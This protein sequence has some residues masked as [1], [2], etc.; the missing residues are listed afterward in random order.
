MKKHFLQILVLS[1]FITFCH[2]KQLPSP[3]EAYNFY[4]SC[5]KGNVNDATQFLTAYP[6]YADIPLYET[7]S[8]LKR[9]IKT[10]TIYNNAS[11]QRFFNYLC[12]EGKIQFTNEEIDNGK[13]R[14]L[15]NT[16]KRY[17]INVAARYGN[18]EIVKL[19]LSY[20]ADINICEENGNT[21]L[22]S[23]TQ[24]NHLEV[25]KEL[26]NKQ[27]KVNYKNDND[28]TAL[29][30]SI[31]NNYIEIVEY[32][33]EN[34]ADV[35]L[36]TEGYTPLMFASHYGKI[37]IVKLL[38][39]KNANINAQTQE[40][41]TALQF[42]AMN[43]EKE[44]TDLLISNGADVNAKNNTGVTALMEA[45]YKNDF[46]ITKSL[47]NANVDINAKEING[48]NALDIA[49]SQYEEDKKDK[50][51]V[52]LLIRS[53][54]E[55]SNLS[56]DK[57]I[58][59]PPKVIPASDLK[60]TLSNEDDYVIIYKYIGKYKNIIFPSQIEGFPVRQIGSNVFDDCYKITFERVEIP[61]S[62]TV[63]KRDAFTGSKI[64][65]LIIP[66]NVQRIESLGKISYLE[67]LV[68]PERLQ[69]SSF[70]IDFS[71]SCNL[72]E[73]KFPHLIGSSPSVSIYTYK[74]SK[75]NTIVFPE[76]AHYVSIGGDIGNIKEIHLPTSTEYLTGRV[77]LYPSTR[78]IVPFSNQIQFSYYW[79]FIESR[80]YFMPFITSN[81][82]LRERKEI[83]DFWRNLGYDGSFS[84]D[85]LF[86][87]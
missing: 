55:S 40:G 26:L 7:T 13:K 44:I 31:L 23:A 54:A 58:E 51:I 46:E 15:Q 28:L 48:Y 87:F 83:Q 43:K 73:V 5:A 38:L 63:I 86:N 84:D 24:N 62:V 76:E 17:P 64:K 9:Y 75:I 59:Y 71:N 57:Y 41:Q 14:K 50:R 56:M 72:N 12:D 53:G 19:L 37:E 80:G 29:N 34:N 77:L 18:L 22:I 69:Q 78:F 68:L 39:S 10:K 49:I 33:L 82:T 1:I 52:N 79:P 21:P 3:E 65:Q 30:L 36:T 81:C 45:V 74:D 16:Y 66:N 2:Q 25:V 20:N 67:K 4:I 8:D 6:E 11:Y 35:E 60:Y 61:S 32:L 27:A 42:A 70:G 47:I 85:D